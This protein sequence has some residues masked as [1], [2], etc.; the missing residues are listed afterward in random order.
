[1]ALGVGGVDRRC[2][3]PRSC[4][5]DP[6]RPASGCG[7]PPRRARPIG[8]E[9][10]E[11]L[12]GAIE[13]DRA[14]LGH[15]VGGDQLDDPVEPLLRRD[16]LGHDLDQPLAAASARRRTRRSAVARRRASG[17]LRPP[18]AGI[19][20]P[21]ERA[22]GASRAAGQRALGLLDQLGQDRRHRLDPAHQAD[23]LPGHQR[24]VLDVAVDHR[25]AQAHRPSNARSRARP[26]RRSSRRGGSG[27]SPRSGSR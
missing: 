22:G 5:P 2:P 11:H 7:A 4:R 16:R 6:R 12:A 15:E 8:G 27:R 25:A 23:A 1:M 10:L 21:R 18:E 9:Q 3:A 24:A 19:R 20:P 17:G 13:V 14:D 26:P